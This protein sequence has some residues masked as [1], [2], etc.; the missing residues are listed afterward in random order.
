MHRR[1]LLVHLK[2][3]VDAFSLKPRHL[4]RIREAFPDLCLTVT[5][6]QEELLAGLPAADWLLTWSFRPEWYQESPK[7][8][9]VFTPAAG[10][11]WVPP[12]PTGRVRNHYGHFHGRIM[13]ES[14]LA[15]MLYFNRRLALNVAN[16]ERAVWDRGASEGCCALFSQRVL[17]VGYGA[18]GRQMA[19]LLKAFGARITGVRRSTAGSV[20]D[21]N[22]ERIVTF[23]RLEEELPVAD[24]VVLMLPGGAETTDLFTEQHFA[25]MKPGSYLYNLGRGNCY[26]EEHLVHAL[27]AG[28]L[29]GAGLDVFR[30]EPLPPSS[31]LWKLPNV[32][33]TPHA[34]AISREYLDLYIEEW[35]ETFMSMK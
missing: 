33:I 3:Q 29:A 26:R 2:N 16:Q 31:P 20:C 21:P 12:D 19:E 11:D 35:I 15:M 7:L 34:S 13:R 8:T 14:L 6:S 5:T 9:A 4:D 22:V 25:R 23:A 27:L 1:N 10:N 18:I 32:L 17:I 24:H 30:V 28:P